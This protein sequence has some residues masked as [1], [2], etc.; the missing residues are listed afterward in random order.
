MTD[1][2]ALAAE[3]DAKADELS[4]A[5]AE[6]TAPTEAG[7]AIGF[8]KRV[9]EGTTQAIHQMEGAFVAR[10][11]Y[12]LLEQVRRARVKI[13]EGSYGRCDVCDE[14]I[15]PARLELRPWSTT[16]VPHAS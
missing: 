12:A 7:S 11:T 10:N 4:A 5:L 16:C 2:Q 1:L 14:T 9:G 15:P 8:G 13:D 3:L 6:L